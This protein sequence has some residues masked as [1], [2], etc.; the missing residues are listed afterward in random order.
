[1][2]KAKWSEGL[3]ALGQLVSERNEKKRIHREEDEQ[4]EHGQYDADPR[5]S[6]GFFPMT[7]VRDL[8]LEE[9]KKCDLKEAS[10]LCDQAD[11][12]LRRRSEEQR[13]EERR[14]Y[15]I[16]TAPWHNWN[17]NVGRGINNLRQG[18]TTLSG[19]CARRSPSPDKRSV[20]YDK[21]TYPM[22]HPS[23]ATSTY[24]RPLQQPSGSYGQR[25]THSNPTPHQSSSSSSAWSN[26]S[27]QEP[28]AS[29]RG[30]IAYRDMGARDDRRRGW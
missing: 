5:L 22:R 18:L 19:K 28:R 27:K 25:R 17:V 16:K 14:A 3:S 13:A 1:M 21:G 15:D 8:E 20:P 24:G 30:S 6:K 12:H 7:T 29:S 2:S 4:M 10:D 26:W 9:K 11:D 23:S